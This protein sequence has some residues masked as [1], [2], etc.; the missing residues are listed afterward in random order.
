M[1]FGANDLMPFLKRNAKLIED[2][3]ARGVADATLDPLVAAEALSWMVSR[4]AYSVF[5]LG[6]PIPIDLLTETLNQRGYAL[7]LEAT[8]D[9]G[10]LLDAARTS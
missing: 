7:C 10:S 2:L 9:P 5:V 8:G 6:S 1:N 4:M 3:Q